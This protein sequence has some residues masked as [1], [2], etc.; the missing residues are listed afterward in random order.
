MNLTRALEVALPDIPARK[1]AESTPRLDPGTTFR[2][3]DEGGKCTV[4]IYVP[5]VFGM[6][7]L[8][9]SEWE[10]VR[11]FDGKRSY[12]KIAELYSQQNAVQYDADTVRE[13]AAGL[14]ASEF[15]YKTPQ[16]KNIQLMQMSLEERKKKLKGK[17][18]W[19]DLSDVDFPAFN[20][21]R[22]ITWAHNQTRFIYTPW[23]TIVCL[24]GVFT[25]VGITIAN[26]PVVWQDTYNF[27]TFSHRTWVD[28]I[29]MYTLGMF[30]V[31]VHEFAHAHA[32]KHY[33]GRVPA[34]GFALVY[35]L[36]AFYTDTTE[37]FVHGTFYQRLIISFAGVWSEMIM[38][39][40]ATP[41]WWATPPDTLIHD[42]AHFIMM[43]CGIMSLVLNWNPLIK[44]DGYYMLADF[45]GIPNLK[46]ES[47]A[48]SSA[49]VK[50]QIWGLPVDVPFIPKRR[51]VGYVVY[52]LISG[53]YSYSVLY[54]LAR[55]AGNFVRNFSPEWGFIPEIGVALII[56]RSRIRL[57]VNFMKFLY[58]DKKDLIRAWFT[59]KHTAMTVGILG[60]L[61]VGPFWRESVG[62]KFVLEPVNKA[63]VRAHV[64]GTIT[65]IFV[66]E[67]Q[68]VSEGS[69]L[70]TLSNLSLESGLDDANARLA[71]ASAQTRE[72][73]L[74]YRDYGNA[75]MERER[76]S[77][78]VRQS[79][80][81]TGALELKAPLTGT[82]VTPKVHDLLGS[83]L[84]TGSELLEIADLTELRARIYISEY[85]L[86]KVRLGES[87]KIQLD[88]RMGRIDGKVN[89]VTARP[90]EGPILEPQVP[91]NQENAGN[92]HQFYSV[93]ILV[94]NPEA[95]LRPGMTGVSRVY[96]ARRSVG[97]LVLEQVK[98]FWG[99]KLW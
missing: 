48:Y 4:R 49:W 77:K 56:F 50:K 16:E 92:P 11:L 30:V 57:L 5:S 91:E 65:K 46:E 13:F 9:K 52:S 1:L 54:I 69:P 90:V 29:Y 81:M 85:D 27:Y 93:D 22:F 44:L 78:Q 59:A 47:T 39:A 64:P 8:E 70:A 53:A 2:E 32:C 86:Y 10:L 94:E 3:H 97:G 23:F 99:R 95:N 51:R 63:V 68:T 71:M 14:E 34:M 82:I 31:G 88:G 7:S 37:G 58:L 60:V 55:F 61:L 38:Y 25:S 73:A 28:V 79:S 72:A 43:M 74:Q 45:V 20:P 96:G 98:N 40:L 19:A 89:F 76:S 33:G 42:S 80:E 87:A 35:L 36:P 84:K 26:W 24:L 17:N 41:I 66:R 18:I 6:Y 75:L 12:E 21:D 15:W 83:Y 62:G 67:G